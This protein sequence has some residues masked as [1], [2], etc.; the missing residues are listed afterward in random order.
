[1]SAAETDLWVFRDG[2]KSVSGARLLNEL[3]A[4]LK[5]LLD[6]SPSQVRGRALN[7]L[8]RAG[9]LESALA[10]AG[11]PTASALA[12]MTDAVAF[13][14]LASDLRCVAKLA[15][16]LS[17]LSLPQTIENS[18]P[19]GFAY[20]A[21]HPL[22]FADAA[23]RLADPPCPAA[24]IGI[25]NIGT[26]LSAVVVATLRIAGSPA[27]RMTVRPAGHPYS[28]YTHFTSE[29]IRWIEGQKERR[30]MFLVVDEGPG[31]SGSSFLSVGEALIGAG[32]PAAEITLVGSKAADV[33]LLCADDAARR[34]QAFHFLAATSRI[35]SR[36]SDHIFV[37]AGEWRRKML[38]QEATWPACWPQMERVKFVSPDGTR[39]YKFE[40]LGPTGESA[41][42]RSR[43]VDEA[44]FGCNVSD[45][46]G[47]F[48][49]YAVA[50]GVPMTGE[51]V[52]ESVLER[53]AQYCAFRAAEFRVDVKPE[54]LAEML[55]FNVSREFQ[56]ELNLNL[57][58]LQPSSLIVVDGHMQPHEW[59]RTS[60]GILLKTDA[61]THGDDH[62][63]P[64]PTDIA[65]DLAG[66]AVEWNLHPDAMEFLLARFS[67]LTGND[68][69][70]RLP[71]FMLAYSVFRMAWCK[72]AM[73]TGIDSSEEFRLR[74]AYRRYR[75]LA[76][77]QMSGFGVRAT[78]ATW[79]QPTVA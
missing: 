60:D 13:T 24:I 32:V 12:S 55:R 68:V 33:N 58:A 14:L 44:G 75:H 10:D 77:E 62:F 7:T 40:G 42:Q 53:I 26:T 72:M 6:S 51:E 20:Y 29:Q 54:P 79:K 71:V 17:N 65:W 73:S 59:L 76:L 31:R 63:F 22:D 36:F 74:T 69:R 37:G 4:A 5:Q 27:E 38:P 15:D 52:D 57:Q 61:S 16:S 48:S 39:L 9:E 25:R 49:C 47:G 19:E 1:M 56:I 41:Q 11:S 67:Q 8:I 43:L 78:A 28:R 30:A 66:V 23:M 70:R 35:S 18:P 46:G 21:L 34:W 3:R 50:D 45:A 2:R 64:G